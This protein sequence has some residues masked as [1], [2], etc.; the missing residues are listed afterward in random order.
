MWAN[1][2]ETLRNSWKSDSITINAPITVFVV[3]ANP[4]VRAAKWNLDDMYLESDRTA[5]LYF[6]ACATTKDL[7]WNDQDLFQ[8]QK[9]LKSKMVIKHPWF[10]HYFHL[11]T[12]KIKLTIY[13]LIRSSLFHFK[14][15]C[16]GIQCKNEETC[17]TVQITVDNWINDW[18][19][20][21]YTN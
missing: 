6:V 18:T 15:N 1:P 20:N 14:M 9:L 11:Q 10:I 13:T 8:G 16:G 5:S 7:K 17:V 21:N 12:L 3:M 2:P 4:S 19:G